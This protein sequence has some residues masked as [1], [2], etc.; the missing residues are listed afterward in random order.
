[1]RLSL[2]LAAIVLALSIHSASA[3]QSDDEASIRAVLAQETEGW[4]KFDAK[5]VASTFTTDAVWQNP[6]GVRIH[7]NAELEKFLTDLMARPD[8][9][10]VKAPCQ[11]R[12]WTS[13][14]PHPPPLPCGATRRLKASS[15]M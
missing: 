4:D 10:P 6:F 15:T 14:S 9:V 1:M 11:R 12:S 7:G 5:E 2:A 3:Q 8:I 13:A